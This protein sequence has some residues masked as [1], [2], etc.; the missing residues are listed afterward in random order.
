MGSQDRVL[1]GSP[2]TPHTVRASNA[3]L[4]HF[5]AQLFSTAS[6]VCPQSALEGFKP[7]LTARLGQPERVPETPGSL[8]PPQ[9]PVREA[10][11][12]AAEEVLMGVTCSDIIYRKDGH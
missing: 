4:G 6:V 5:Q 2:Q 12:Q 9:P 7:V 1:T 11:G 10:G 3:D 8:P